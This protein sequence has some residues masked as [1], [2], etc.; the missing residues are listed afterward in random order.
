MR[1]KAAIDRRFIKSGM[2]LLAIKGTNHHEI[3]SEV[4]RDFF[5]SLDEITLDELQGIKTSPTPPAQ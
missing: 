2:K 4:Q 3:F 5:D 1:L